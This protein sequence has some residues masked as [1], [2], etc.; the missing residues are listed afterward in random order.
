MVMALVKRPR[1][2]V[3]VRLGSVLL[4][5]IVVILVYPMHVFDVSVDKGTS[6]NKSDRDSY[7]KPRDV[8]TYNGVWQ[9]VNGSAGV[10]LFSAFYDNR[11]GNKWPMVRTISVSKNGSDSDLRCLLWFPNNPHPLVTDTE[12]SVVGAWFQPQDREVF[13]AVIL[14]CAV[15]AHTGRPAAIPEYVSIVTPNETVPTTLLRVQ[16]PETPEHTIAFGHCMSV[17]YW[18]QDPYRIVE[19]MELHRMWGVGEVTVY[20]NSLH[21]ATSRV[22]EHYAKEGFVDFRQAPSAVDSH[23]DDE[24]TI[25]LNMSPVLNDCMY[26]NLYRYRRLVV[27]DIDEM[28]V[29]RLHD[30]YTAMLAAIDAPFK[31]ANAK[32]ILQSAESTRQFV[33]DKHNAT[34]EEQ[35]K[36]N[37]PNSYMFNNVYFFSDLNATRQA[38]WFLATQRYLRHIK[39]SPF[40]YSVKSIF[41]PRA[42]IGLQNHFC[43]IRHKAYYNRTWNVDVPLSIGMNQHYKKCHFDEYLRKPGYCKQLAQ[44]VSVDYAMVRFRRELESR[45]LV[46]LKQLD[47]VEP[48]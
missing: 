34:R 30:N 1:R 19:W 31:K 40:G 15:H 45:V 48:I 17:A 4:V 13:H 18:H 25:L 21:P 37:P 6:F 43:W 44:N 5:G 35:T 3:L 24:Q 46:V 27:T 7:S 28:I 29:P 39:P 23:R 14:S 41:N 16:V 11:P 26:R 22:Y 2:F 10:Y 12:C 32:D 38:P 36:V 47:L 42:C 33:A 20:N 8:Q 9:A